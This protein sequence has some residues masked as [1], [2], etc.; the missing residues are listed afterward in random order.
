V[1]GIVTVITA[2]HAFTTIRVCLRFIHSFVSYFSLFSL[3]CST[4]GVLCIQVYRILQQQLG[5]LNISMHMYIWSTTG[6]S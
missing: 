4:I 2:E 6:F 1:E 3:A 5:R